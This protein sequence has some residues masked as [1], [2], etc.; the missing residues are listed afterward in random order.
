MLSVAIV[1]CGKIADQH[2]EQILRIPGS[3]IVA[4]C[5]REE[6]MARQLQERLDL[7]L[8]VGHN[9]QFS[10][11]ANRMRK[12]VQEGFL[13]GFPLHVESY[14]CYDLGDAGYAKALLGDSS[15]WVRNLPGGLLQN[16]ISHGIS[17]IAE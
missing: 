1:G 8:T 15:H 5:D 2:A 4:V 11:A 12:L 14:Y 6:L 17:K 7:K 13:G 16:T 9:A 3:Q 10:H